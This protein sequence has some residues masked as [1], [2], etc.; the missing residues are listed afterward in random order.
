MF[1]VAFGPSFGRADR[2]L[3]VR[4]SALVVVL[5]LPGRT[6]DVL[7]D[8]LI[9]VIVAALLFVRAVQVR[10]DCALVQLVAGSLDL[11]VDV[12]TM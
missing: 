1:A 9:A 10:V 4:D 5:T 3:V 7:V 12:W 6:L 2:V 11:D 8:L